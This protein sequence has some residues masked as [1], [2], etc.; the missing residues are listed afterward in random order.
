ME[1]AQP[2][3]Q[4][5]AQSSVQP[6]NQAGVNPAGSG[7]LLPKIASKR[8]ILVVFG[9]LGILLLVLLLI[10]GLRNSGQKGDED[11]VLAT[12]G[13]REIKKSEVIAEAQKQYLPDAIDNKVLKTF[14]DILIE[15]EI[16]DTEAQGLGIKVSQSEAVKRAREINSTVNIN[17]FL[18]TQARYDLLKDKIMGQFVNSRTVFAVSFWTPSSKYPSAKSP[19]GLAEAGRQQ[20][21]AN[22]A[23]PEIEKLIL[24]ETEPLEAVKLVM[25]NEEYSD[26]K[27]IIAVN[28]AIVE[29]TKDE[30]VM[31]TPKVL[32]EADKKAYGE[33][34]YG[35]IFNSK[36]GDVILIWGEE[37]ASALL[38]KVVDAKDAKFATFD[39]W[40][41]AK[42]QELVKE[43]NK[44]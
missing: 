43:V 10:L 26:L 38:F 34:F 11:L 15:R 39:Q 22:S 6:P 12:V 16:L 5:N 35:E 2:T 23:F 18:V 33:L 14:L 28:G 7:G 44:I 8:L 31:K 29:L 19:E 30:S 20:Q 9:I 40:Y 42:R 32:T 4:N 36:I 27:K 25:Q 41:G 1:N 3:A 37:R 17:G 21:Q 13:E 24:E